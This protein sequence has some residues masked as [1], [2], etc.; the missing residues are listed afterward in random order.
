[1]F[2]RH[3]S[4]ARIG[5]FD[6]FKTTVAALSAFAIG[7]TV[8]TGAAIGKKPA[9]S[10]SCQGLTDTIVGTQGAN[11]INGTSGADVITAGAGNDQ[12]WGHGGDDV[13]C[14][15]PG[16]DTIQAVTERTSSPGSRATT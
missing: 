6:M 4:S 3:G 9:K 2:W 8:F 5:G 16:T 11:V 7:L 14:G 10:G 13:V 15:G 1:M 12:V